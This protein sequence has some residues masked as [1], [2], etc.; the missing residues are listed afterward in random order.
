MQ[1]KGTRQGSWPLSP[2][3]PTAGASA[4]PK[5]RSEF[6]MA[7]RAAGPSA[8]FDVIDVFDDDALERLAAYGSG[9][10]EPL[11]GFWYPEDLTD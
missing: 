10:V 11:P 8:M 1:A 7:L 3:W 2:S 6:D 4:L 9:V 5:H